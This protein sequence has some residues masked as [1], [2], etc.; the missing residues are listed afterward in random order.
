MG[1]D[2][3][4]LPPIHPIGSSH[5][6]GSDNALEAG[7]G[8]PGS[9]WAIGSWEGGHAA[10][11]PQLGSL[12]DFHAFMREAAALGLEVAIDLAFQCSPDHPWVRDHPEWFRHGPDGVIQ[13]AQNPPKMYQDIYPL[14]FSGPSSGPLWLEARAVVE[15]WVAQGVR[16][17]RVDNPHTKPF[18][19]WRWLIEQVSREHPDVI[20]LAEAFT[21]PKVMRHLAKLGFA[22]SYVHFPWQNTKQELTD[23]FSREVLA[24]DFGEYL[25]PSL[26]TNTPDILTAYLREGGRPAFAIRLLLAATMA[27]NYGI[28]GPAFELCWAAARTPGE[29]E[30]LAS[31]KYQLRAWDVASGAVLA[32]LISQVNRIRRQLPALTRGD[33]PRFWESDSDEVIAYCRSDPQDGDIAVVAVGLNPRRGCRA[34]V[35][36]PQ[37]VPPSWAR[38]SFV[39]DLLSG[40]VMPI[41]AGGVVLELDPE[42]SPGAIM[43]PAGGAH[44]A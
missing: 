26:W 36:P 8:D 40:A 2:V 43:V 38:A 6:K 29:E 32:P 31:E 23:Y 13:H 34:R 1:F 39:Q 11:H 30:Y 12:D 27:G 3:V 42:R 44:S 9:P 4:Y 17:F 33:G 5:R 35:P 14:D 37:A 22:Q 41:S 10:I 28:Y 16:I 15:H 21:R 24:S 7:P 25:R 18:E 19:F 20:F